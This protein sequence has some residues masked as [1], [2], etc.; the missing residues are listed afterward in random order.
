MGTGTQ[1][2]RPSFISFLGAL[3]GSRI[4]SRAAGLGFV[5]LR[6]PMSHMLHPVGHSIGFSDILIPTV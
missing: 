5:P 6:T 3:E 1:A 4:G 2:I